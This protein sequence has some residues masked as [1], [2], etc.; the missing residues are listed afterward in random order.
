MRA[1]V[2]TRFGAPEV[3]R[4]VEVPTPIPKPDEV[5]VRIHAA[6]VTSAESGMRQGRPLWGRVVLGFTRPRRR[7]RTLGTEL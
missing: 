7:M 2:Y 3:L 4:L 6:T 5:L 1:V